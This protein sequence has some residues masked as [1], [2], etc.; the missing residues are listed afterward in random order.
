MSHPTN[1]LERA[2]ISNKKDQKRVVYFEQKKTP[3]DKAV[4]AAKLTEDLTAF[5]TKRIAKTYG[6]RVMDL[7]HQI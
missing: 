4:S 7:I 1:K 5:D 6:I 3:L 2:V